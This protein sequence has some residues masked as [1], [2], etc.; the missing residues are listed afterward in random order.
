MALQESDTKYAC[1]V[2]VGCGIFK[3][4]DLGDFSIQKHFSLGSN[5]FKIF[6]EL[7]NLMNLLGNAVSCAINVTGC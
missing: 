5:I 2:S 1:V 7:R 6:G 4:D 3:P